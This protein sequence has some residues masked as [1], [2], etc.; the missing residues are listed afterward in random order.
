MLVPEAR[1]VKAPIMSL[2]LEDVFYRLTHD[3]I[4]DPRARGPS[5]VSTTRYEGT[6]IA[7]DLMVA[8]GGGP[9]ADGTGRGRPELLQLTP[10]VHHQAAHVVQQPI[11]AP[12]QPR[13]VVHSRL[14]DQTSDLRDARP[15]PRAAS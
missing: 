8:V 5:A 9:S 14:L 7:Q 12:R 4:V 1:S 3:R 2:K 10:G 11:D 13:P 6:G 15:P